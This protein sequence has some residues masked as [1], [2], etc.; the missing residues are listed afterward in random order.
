M[1]PPDSNPYLHVIAN[2]VTDSLDFMLARVIRE[3][4]PHECY[5]KELVRALAVAELTSSRAAL[6]K[7]RDHFGI[8]INL[9]HLQADIKAARS[10]ELT[11]QADGINVSGSS[12]H[13][14][15][16]QACGA[17][18]KE[19]AVP[20]MFFMSHGI[21]TLIRSADNQAFEAV[22]FTPERMRGEI[23]RAIP[24][25]RFNQS[26]NC[27]PVPAPMDV[28]KDI[29]SRPE[30]IGLPYL[31]G[32]VHRPFL[33]PDGTLVQGYGYDVETQTFLDSKEELG[34]IPD[35]EISASRSAEWLLKELFCDFPFDC[36]AS[37][38]NALAV[39]LT[40]CVRNIIPGP[41]PAAAVSGT[42]HGA[43][44][45]KIAEIVSMID[46]GYEATLSGINKNEEEIEKQITAIF[47][48]NPAGLVV[49]DNIPGYLD[50]AN[51]ARA[52]TGKWDGRI[53]GQ[54]QQVSMKT[55]CTFI[56]TGNNLSVSN[57]LA[58]RSYL[59]RIEPKDSNPFYRENLRHQ[60]LLQWISEHRL[61]ILRHVFTIA[62]AW[63]AAGKPVWSSTP[64][65][66][67][68][69]YTQIIGGMLENA[70]IHHFMGNQADHMKLTDSESGEW[71][72]FLEAIIDWRGNFEWTASQLVKELRADGMNANHAL[73]ESMPLAI[74]SCME[75]RSPEIPM[76]RILRNR[77]DR[78]YGQKN[79]RISTDGKNV[80]PL[81]WM[82]LEG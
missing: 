40:A 8:R 47:K 68:E 51:M 20:Y 36:V 38:H 12:L 46:I 19:N 29:L 54:T 57:E 18:L 56:W 30:D 59:I 52:I 75:K 14:M 58:R 26:G 11:T 9:N 41:A 72:A 66:S 80:S 6:R 4:D 45:S 39:V 22:Q 7:L 60:D 15:T 73:R 1:Q 37:R 32:I 78:R 64:L 25:V 17:L 27:T 44:K 70:G 21:V 5:G 24:W 69:K 31:R 62:R 13:V 63:F 2:N 77:K 28:A 16:Q 23:D 61:E 43:G 42:A 50:S 65:G 53:L 81:R 79:L 71:Q 82:I 76:G 74:S 49:F 33:R 55:A 67:F 48:R 35:D 3:N 10:S 34:E